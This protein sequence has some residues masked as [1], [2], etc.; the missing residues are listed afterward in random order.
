MLWHTDDAIFKLETKCA[1]RSKK[2]PDIGEDQFIK[3]CERKCW[4]LPLGEKQGGGWELP[5]LNKY[6]HLNSAFNSHNSP[7]QHRQEK[8]QVSFLC[9]CVCMVL[10]FF[11][12]L[13][14]LLLPPLS[15]NL[16]KNLFYKDHWW[17]LGKRIPLPASIAITETVANQQC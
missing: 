8:N 7:L 6:H 15:Q 1:N 17:A 10:F 11:F 5:L 9:V 14:T 12:C 4:I 16:M 13:Q 2:T 3:V